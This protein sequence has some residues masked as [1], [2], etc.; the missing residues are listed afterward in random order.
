MMAK[1][2]ASALALRLR[3]APLLVPDGEAPEVKLKRR[4]A[5]DNRYLHEPLAPRDDAAA[6]VARSLPVAVTA[7][8]FGRAIIG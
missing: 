5:R 3:L 6:G 1:P 4:T 7:P 2:Q 8:N